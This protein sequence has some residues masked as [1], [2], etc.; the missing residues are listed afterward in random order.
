M[1]RKKLKIYLDTSFISY[2]K[3][4]DTPEKMNR[5]LEVWEKFK[6]AKYHICISDITIVE[7]QECYEPK[8]TILKEYLSQI[9]YDILSVD[10]EVY[11]LSNKYILDGVFKE[12]SLDD[13]QHVA[14]ATVNNCDIILSW[15]FKHIV[16]HT[17][18]LGVNG[19]N[20]CLCY[21]EILLYS[22]FEFDI[23]EE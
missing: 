8:Q 15:N 21:K 19:I 6:L 10:D 7:I 23:E 16:K 1:K 3:Q 22:P 17:T 12:K 13:S 2:L 4:E 18:F 5:T 9:E 20:K 11:Q 14:V